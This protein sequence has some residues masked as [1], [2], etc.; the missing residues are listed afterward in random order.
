[1][2]DYLW[3][4]D[5]DINEVQRIEVPDGDFILELYQT[6][7]TSEA[8]DVVDIYM[9]LNTLPSTVPERNA[10]H[11]YDYGDHR[12]VLAVTSALIS[13]I[14]SFCWGGKQATH[15]YACDW[16]PS[17]DTMITTLGSYGITGTIVMS[18]GMRKTTTLADVPFCSVLPHG[19]L[20]LTSPD[21][22]QA[23]VKLG[24]P[25][26]ANRRRG[27]RALLSLSDGSSLAESPES[28]RAAESSVPA[29]G[30]DRLR[31]AG[32]S[33][34]SPCGAHSDC[35]QTVVDPFLNHTGTFCGSVT[36]GASSTCQYCAFCQYDYEGVNG[37]CL[38]QCGI[39][40]DFPQCID[41][42]DLFKGFSCPS[43]YAFS[44]YQ[45]NPV[46]SA[47]TVVP[48][49]QPSLPEVTPHN[50]L[51]GPIVVTQLRNA[52]GPCSEVQSLPMR[53]F[54]NR[55]TCPLNRRDATPYGMDPAFL[56]SS[57]DYDGKL[58]MGDFYVDSELQTIQTTF[59]GS[60]FLEKVPRARSAR[61]SLVPR[62]RSGGPF[63]RICVRRIAIVPCGRRCPTAST[64]TST[65]AT[66]TS[67]RTGRSSRR[68]TW[69]PLSSTLTAS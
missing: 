60:V 63:P 35:D 20:G 55:T 11:D 58:S 47:P 28:V 10:T 17:L 7:K 27:R 2:L 24:I 12:E 41:G 4:N 52:Q 29:E 33:V 32:L 62:E 36:A 26:P 54:S 51:V 42:E 34:G 16:H 22:R 25:C 30:R 53:V 8:V 21:N 66:R 59:P 23:L 9:N 37:H 43:K 46:G 14:N 15:N 57:A 50:F 68:A 13:D 18:S 3:S 44:V 40:G 56:S 31:G 49:S 67:A 1:M 5:M 45:Y 19:A 38:A 64:P 48:G 69:T 6:N 65:T 61:V 39:S